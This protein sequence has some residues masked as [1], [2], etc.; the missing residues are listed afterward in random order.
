MKEIKFDPYLYFRAIFP[1]C[2]YANAYVLK[3]GKMESCYAEID[4]S[5]FRNGCR[6]SAHSCQYRI[7]RNT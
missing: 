6:L 4:Y 1:R 2:S 3:N 5:E 7:T